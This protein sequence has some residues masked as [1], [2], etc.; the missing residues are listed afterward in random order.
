V[1]DGESIAVVYAD[2]ADDSGLSRPVRHPSAEVVSVKFADAMR[3]HAVA[4]LLRLRRELKGQGELR[5][6]AGSLFDEVEQ[7]YRAD[8]AAGTTGADLQKRLHANLE[9]ARSIFAHRTAHESSAVTG[10][11]EAQLQG[12]V[13]LHRES[14][15]GRDL[16]LVSEWGTDGNAAAPRAANAS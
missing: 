15:F 12:M 9:Y 2:D 14:A 3:Q 1:V 7:M 16:T 13:D 11:L 5:A 10:L 4:L 6:Y 8:E